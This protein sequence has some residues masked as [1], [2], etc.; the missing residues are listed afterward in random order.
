ME[1]NHEPRIYAMKNMIPVIGM[2]ALAATSPGEERVDAST[3]TGKVMCGYQGWFR[4]PG[5]GSGLEWI[6]YRNQS[7][8]KFRPGH[9]GIDFWPDIDELTKEE[10][11]ATPFRHADGRTAAV[12][13]SHH[14]ATVSRHF[15]WMK[16][17]HPI[18]ISGWSARLPEC[19]A[20]KSLTRRKCQF[21][22]QPETR[23]CL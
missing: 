15:R 6:H 17:C 3:L 4:C 14:P 18:I 12:F 5:D 11:F 10:K 19:C 23:P 22:K 7:S 21:A 8:H 16:D 13:S 2:F 9:A 20:V 1:M